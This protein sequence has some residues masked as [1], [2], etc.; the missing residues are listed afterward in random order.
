[1]ILPPQSKDLLPICLQKV[2]TDLKD[3]FPS[4]LE[5]NLVGKRNIWESTISNM[6]PIDLNIF[7]NYFNSKK[8]NKKKINIYENYKINMIK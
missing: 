2:F 1:M 8:M 5:F 4:K 3:F 7:T 6:K